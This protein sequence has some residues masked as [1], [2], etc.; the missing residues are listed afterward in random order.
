MIDQQPQNFVAQESVFPTD[1]PDV[2]PTAPE[3]KPMSPTVYASMNPALLI[4][5][6]VIDMVMGRYEL[7]KTWRRTR[8]II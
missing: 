4:D 5:Q 2:M 7:S 6:E 1:R 8:R 3:P